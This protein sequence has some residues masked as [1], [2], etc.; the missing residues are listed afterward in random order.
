MVG[1]GCFGGSASFF[2]A[3][4]S[5]VEAFFS[6]TVVAAGGGAAGVTVGAFSFSGLALTRHFSGSSKAAFS[7]W[8][9]SSDLAVGGEAEGGG[10]DSEGEGEKREKFC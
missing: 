7:S 6:V 1:G 5:G 10:G 9:S 8:A 2:S 4:F 3:G